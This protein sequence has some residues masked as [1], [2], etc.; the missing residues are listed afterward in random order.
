MVKRR[1][2]IQF[3]T[4]RGR[5][6]RFLRTHLTLATARKHFYNILGMTLDNPNTG[7]ILVFPISELEREIIVDHR[8]KLLLQNS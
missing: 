3:I 6:R 8:S 2:K 5:S 1:G 4:G 7:R